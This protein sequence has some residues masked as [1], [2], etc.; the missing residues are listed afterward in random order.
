MAAFQSILGIVMLVTS[1][2]AIAIAIYNL[3]I[4]SKATIE[5][6]DAKATITD[7]ERKGAMAAN[8]VAI[9]AALLIGVYGIVILLPAKG[10][11]EPYM[12]PVPSIL[13]TERS[14]SGT[15]LASDY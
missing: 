1:I 10:P 9:V 15:V 8:V 4:I 6:S 13:R 11:S 5:S 3:T 7:G 14:L 2:I 12:P